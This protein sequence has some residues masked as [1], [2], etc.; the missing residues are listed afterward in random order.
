MGLCLPA[1]CNANDH[2]A[3]VN[4]L[5]TVLQKMMGPNLFVGKVVDSPLEFEF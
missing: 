3:I 4:T 5:N 2:A 1:E